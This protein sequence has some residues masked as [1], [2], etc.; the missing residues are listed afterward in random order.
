MCVLHTEERDDA[1]HRIRVSKYHTKFM[2]VTSFSALSMHVEYLCVR[3]FSLSSSVAFETEKIQ[4]NKIFDIKSYMRNARW[5]NT[6]PFVNIL[7]WTVF[8]A[9]Q[10]PKRCSDRIF[11]SAKLSQ[12]KMQRREKRDRTRAKK[13][14]SLLRSN[15]PM[16]YSYFV[17][18]YYLTKLGYI[19]RDS[20]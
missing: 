3:F 11:L 19:Q 4:M 2:L 14:K 1:H 6:I 5:E 12:K 7:L 20:L 17:W 18:S 8:R 15:F 13:N 10:M 9:S 16:F